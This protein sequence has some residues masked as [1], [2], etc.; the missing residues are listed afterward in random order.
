M[1]LDLPNAASGGSVEK[2]FPMFA[3]SITRKLLAPLFA[4]VSLVLVLGVTLSLAQETRLVL[5]TT[6]SPQI[7]TQTPPTAPALLIATDIEL[8]D[9]NFP[10]KAPPELIQTAIRPSAVKPVN[11]P[12]GYTPAPTYTIP[13]YHTPNATPAPIGNGMY[14]TDPE[15]LQLRITARYQDP[16]MLAFLNST[17]MR[18]MSSLFSEASRRIDTRHVNPLSYEKRTD[19]A[20]EGLLRALNN[21]EFLKVAGAQGT[22]ANLQQAI[23]NISQ[24]IGANPARSAEDALGTMQ[25]A[26]DTL[27][28]NLGLRQE[29]VALEFMNATLDS[30]DR[31]SAFVPN[32]ASASMEPSASTNDQTA[33]LEERIVG[34]GIEMKQ[35]D[36]GALIMGT[37]EGGSAAATGLKKGDILTAINHQNLTGMGLGQVAELI[38]GS[39]GTTVHIVINRA[40]KKYEATLLRQK[41][42][43]SSVANSQMVNDTVGYIRVKQFSD[44]STEDLE[45]A[46]LKLYNNSQMDT[47]VLD[48]RG[49]PG[50]LLTEA[51][52]LS[53]LF[54]PSGVI[55]ST[56]GRTAADNST[57][58]AKRT[59]TWSLPL[60]VLIDENSASASEIFAAAIQ[61][62]GRGVIVGRHSYGKGT[63]QTHFPLNTASAVLKLTTA[64][65]Y[66]PSGR[67]MAGVGVTPDYAVTDVN[68]ETATTL[69]DDNDVRTAVQI[70]QTGLPNQLAQAAGQG[71]R[72]SVPMATSPRVFEE[73][74]APATER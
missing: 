60:I 43:V 39:E 65:F 49:N 9:E 44:S 34:V 66:A 48:M 27:N 25:W 63:V 5:P 12:S 11:N 38:S 53:D 41:V 37:I 58:S 46:M 42:Y 13:A 45:K 7:N 8:R 21:P 24:M 10:V 36:Q 4:M 56:K 74:P 67:E 30:L 55:V 59:K 51:I 35:H 50:G 26:A 15:K 70:A 1:V 20:L 73:L 62:N 52:Q 69:A 3:Q 33:G 23:S 61:E 64:K 2:D 17:S 16:K 47:L 31:F 19:A 28:R 57:E 32:K 68:D 72:L 71:K 29:V 6:D 18:Q 40:G 54:L 22:D 14:E